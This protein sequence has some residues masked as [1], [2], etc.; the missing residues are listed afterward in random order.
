MTYDFKQR[1][2]ARRLLRASITRRWG[3]RLRLG[4]ILQMLVNVLP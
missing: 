3:W 1:K 2:L 4:R